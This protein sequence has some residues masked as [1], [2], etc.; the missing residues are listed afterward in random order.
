[1]V[2]VINTALPPFEEKMSRP[3]TNNPFPT[4]TRIL[5]QTRH[6]PQVKL[7][8]PIQFQFQNPNPQ[9]E[10]PE[11]RLTKPLHEYHRALIQFS[12]P[13]PVP[14][15]PAE[16]LHP[17]LIKADSEAQRIAL[18]FWIRPPIYK[19]KNRRA[20]PSPQKHQSQEPKPKGTRPKDTRPNIPSRKPL[21]PKMFNPQVYWKS[22][23]NIIAIGRN[24]A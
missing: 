20:I 14:L 1:V 15:R 9:S 24:Y 19:Q 22:C 23:R 3:P 18:G 17:A 16:P 7:Q 8:T 13:V 5:K 4:A 12:K 21:P 2:W 6:G 10:D 11:L